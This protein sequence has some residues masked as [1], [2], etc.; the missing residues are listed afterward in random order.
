M[1][2]AWPLLP[3]LLALLAG[4]AA[5]P[6]PAEATGHSS[7]QTTAPTAGLALPAWA[8]RD[9]WTYTITAGTASSKATY[10]VTADQGE[11]WMV[12]TDSPERAF[13]NARDDVS[14]LG[15]QRKS[16]LAGSQ[17]G[18]RVQFFQWPLTEGKTWQTRWDHRE[19]T[20]TAHVR[21]ALAHLEAVDANGTRVYNYTYDAA[22]GWFRSLRHYGP[23]GALL[24]DLELDA[25][26]HAWTGT[27][28]R[29]ALRTLYAASGVNGGA[30]AKPVQPDADATDLWL[31]YH[32]RCGA[33]GGGYS[34]AVEPV[35]PGAGTTGYSSEG[36]CASNDFEDGV[37]GSLAG[38]W[39]IAYS[40]G[41]QPPMSYTVELVQRTREDVKVG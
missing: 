21:G 7:A 20:I 35:G 13:Q 18:D 30:D 1:P 6:A 5:K 12:D 4:C 24:I 19:V 9:A 8:V 33:G 26:S 15:P 36:A 29:Y 27:V 11:E 31:A 38:P 25:S 3:L 39:S 23:D 10:V 40:W 34:I 41:G 14:R 17:G 16:D 28:V 22:V 2:R 32:L 37:P